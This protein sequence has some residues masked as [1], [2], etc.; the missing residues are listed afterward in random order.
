VL[1]KICTNPASEATAVKNWGKYLPKVHRTQT[2]L[3][4][5]IF[6]RLSELLIHATRKK[7]ADKE[8]IAVV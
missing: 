4:R 5:V 2:F 8:Y 3:E 7:Y 6:A 1:H